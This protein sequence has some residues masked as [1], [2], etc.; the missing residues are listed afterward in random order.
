M[1]ASGFLQ[2]KQRLL[3]LPRTCRPRRKGEWTE[4]KVVTFIVTLAA[5]RSVTFAAR[6]AGMSRKSAYALRDRDPA[7][8][9]AWE[10]ACAAG[11]SPSV[12]GD[13]GDEG[14]DPRV[15]PRLG[16]TRRRRRANAARAEL[17]DYFSGLFANRLRQPCAAPLAADTALP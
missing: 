13:K 5:L 1:L 14:N 8:A 2:G 7:F 11:A 15:A 12:Q 6:A 10:A 17:S 4:S 9:A 3:H 16:S